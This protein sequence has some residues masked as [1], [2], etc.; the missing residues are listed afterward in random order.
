MK[1]FIFDSSFSIRKNIDCDFYI[2]GFS[3]FLNHTESND[4]MCLLFT[5]RNKSRFLLK[6]INFQTNHTYDKLLNLQITN[7]RLLETV[8]YQNKIYLFTIKKVSSI[9]KVYV[10]DNNSVIDSH[11]F[12]FSHFKFSNNVF[13]CLYDEFLSESH[14]SMQMILKIQKIKTDIPYPIDF[15]TET[16]K[17]YQQHN[18]VYITIDNNIE[19]TILITID[20]ENFK[21]RVNTYLHD[22]LN[23]LESDNVSSNSFL[24]E[25]K[26]F[27]IIVNKNDL[28]LLI[29]DIQKDSLIQA[30]PIYQNQT[31]D[32]EIS[33]FKSTKGSSYF[34]STIN[35]NV[36][37]KKSL[38]K[39][40]NGNSGLV[41]Y[42]ENNLL[43]LK[44]G[45]A[46]EK[47]MIG[48][49]RENKNT[50]LFNVLVDY[51][52]GILGFL[53]QNEFNPIYIARNSYYFSTMFSL[54]SEEFKN[55]KAESDKF[56]KIRE[57]NLGIEKMQTNS[58]IFNY[59][60]YFL[61]GYYQ[62]K[63]N[64]FILRKFE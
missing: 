31:T 54:E 9:M 64:K 20:L 61:Y 57:Y 41:V 23:I 18:N 62:R 16:N 34:Y 55:G 29:R 40:A 7:E 3:T 24:Y 46:K 50:T 28:R 26:L 49:F 47:I 14:Q 44:I 48:D 37:V 43:Y 11:E 13:S 53:G 19:N 56:D 58:Y 59:N 35:E 12:N 51:K 63:S 52:K 25:K 4:S 22:N 8:T 30:F 1:G 6:N 33:R 36:K 27:Q 42:P 17:L 45:G 21:A 10:L 15:V 5:N 38:R 2:K 32:Y 60:D 39:I